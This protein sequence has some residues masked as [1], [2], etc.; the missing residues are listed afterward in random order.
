VKTILQPRVLCI[1]LALA[2]FALRAQDHI[3]PKEKADKAG[4]PATAPSPAQ[5]KGTGR[6][7]RGAPAT[8]GAAEGGRGGAIPPE[9]IAE[10]RKILANPTELAKGRLSFETH[11]V[12][13]HGPKGEG[14]R[15]PTLAQPNL[16]RASEDV[17]LLRIVQRGIP[18]TEMPAVRLKI[19][20][21]PYL[22]AYVRS[23]GNVPAEPVPGNP[24]KGSELFHGKGACMQCH[25]LNGQGLAIGPDLTV[26]GLSRSPTFLRRSLV[27]PSA[28]IPQSFNP[29]R[30][31]ISMPINFAFVSV[32]TKDGKAVSGVRINENTFS[33]QLRDLT[34][35][36]YSFHKTELAELKLDTKQ[37]PM[38]VYANVFT[39]EEMDDIVAY[40]VSLR[41]KPKS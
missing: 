38:P 41:G 35:A 33:I 11:C 32:K 40:L 13:C 5:A 14:S 17:D 26:I 18:N 27:E 28:D 21:A 4:T 3:E 31:E 9:D 25:T 1:L 36:M 10:M 15:G 8:G 20:E 34:G 6:G 12:G 19:G 22:A 24:A 7:G 39:P 23:L 30:A 16:P 2:P 37:S 29:Y